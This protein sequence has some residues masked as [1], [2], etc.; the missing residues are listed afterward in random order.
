MLVSSYMAMEVKGE[1]GMDCVS[2]SVM[3]TYAQ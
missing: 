1:V 3:L 2:Y